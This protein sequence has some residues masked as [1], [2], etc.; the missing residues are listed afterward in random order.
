[1]INARPNING[2]TSEEF[3]AAARQLHN[4][5]KAV[6]EAVSLIKRD[7]MDGRNYQTLAN[8]ID[9]RTADRGRL[10]QIEMALHG[11][12][13]MVFDILKASGS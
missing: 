2:N 12:E 6:R 8:P 11:M 4:A 5:A 9:G 10:A 13:N 7:I 3:T 1:M